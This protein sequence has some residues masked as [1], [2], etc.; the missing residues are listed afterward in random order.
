[1]AKKF[2]C[3]SFIFS[4]TLILFFTSTVLADGAQPKT[5][6]FDNHCYTLTSTSTTIE[7]HAQ[8][9]DKNY[10]FVTITID[11]GEISLPFA[12]TRS[13]SWDG[14]KRILRYPLNLK[15]FDIFFCYTPSFRLGSAT[16][17][18][19]KLVFT[20]YDYNNS[21]I[22]QEQLTIFTEKNEFIL[23]M[24]SLVRQIINKSVKYRLQTVDKMS[25]RSI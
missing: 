10:S 4:L 2:K 25:Q 22:A 13:F 24:K 20:Y 21:I 11:K 14:T 7:I 15:Q 3:L 5:W 1:M 8:C 9:S 19:E 16:N 12:L 18:S 6:K 23:N 17:S